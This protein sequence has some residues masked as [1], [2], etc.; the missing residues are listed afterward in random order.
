VSAATGSEDE[1]LVARVR[2]TL[3]E[4]RAH[5]LSVRVEVDGDAIV[6]R[7]P[8]E[9][10]AAL[11]LVLEEVRRCLADVPRPLRVVD[12]LHVPVLE[13]RPPEEIT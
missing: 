13:D 8:V 12:E 5:R 2:T 9:S 7:G 4:G 6:L 1:H 11:R 10:D 3:A